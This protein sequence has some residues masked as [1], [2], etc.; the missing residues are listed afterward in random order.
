MLFRSLAVH[1]LTLT[2]ESCL[3][4]AK[5]ALAVAKPMATSEI[6]DVVEQLAANNEVAA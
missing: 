5:A 4:M 2:R 1:I 6:C 3:T